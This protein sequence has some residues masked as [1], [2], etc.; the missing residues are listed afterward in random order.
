VESAQDRAREVAATLDRL[1]GVTAAQAMVFLGRVGAGAASKAR[2]LRLPLE[3][4]KWS[5][6][7]Q[8]E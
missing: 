5:T 7:D 6:V 4:L 8:N 1:L 2:S 3:K